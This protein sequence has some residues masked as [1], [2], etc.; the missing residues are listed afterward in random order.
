MPINWET[1]ADVLTISCSGAQLRMISL[2]YMIMNLYV[3]LIATLAGATNAVIA[4]STDSDTAFL[5][6]TKAPLNVRV[7]RQ[8]TRHVPPSLDASGNDQGTF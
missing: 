7:K 5:P 6:D 8:E 3:V 1:I 4:L 2:I